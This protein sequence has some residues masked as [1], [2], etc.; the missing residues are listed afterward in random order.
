M[1]PM[2]QLKTLPDVIITFV[3]TDASS[4]AA[5]LAA[6]KSPYRARMGNLTSTSPDLPA[7]WAFRGTMP[8]VHIDWQVRIV[9]N[10]FGNIPFSMSAGMPKRI[11]PL[12]IKPAE[13][14]CKP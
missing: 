7:I 8:K 6:Q 2:N 1:L 13:H 3:L 9:I 10:Q 14:G 5:A 12:N 11:R 4:G